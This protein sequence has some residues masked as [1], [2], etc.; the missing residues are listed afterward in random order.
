MAYSPLR[1]TLGTCPIGTSPC[2]LKGLTSQ[3]R[4]HLHLIVV[5][6]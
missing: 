2:C 5:D 6:M 1:N 4:D 3:Q